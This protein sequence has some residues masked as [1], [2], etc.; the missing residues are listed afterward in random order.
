MKHLMLILLLPL[1]LNA[2][3]TGL[4]TGEDDLNTGNLGREDD[5]ESAAD[6]YIKL[7][8]EYMKRGNYAVALS[9]AKKAV[10]QD[11]RNANAHLVLA[12]IYEYLGESGSANAA[13]QRSLEVDG[14]NPYALNAYGS[15][16]CKLGE[17]ERA[18]PVFDRAL[19]NPLYQT[20]WVALANAGFCANKAGDLPR[21]QAYLL[22]A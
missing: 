2:C 10:Q 14:K 18:L 8:Q 20:P 19:Q 17:H 21:A 16:L 4:T 6:T 15:Y 7:A 1:F 9:K 5:Y 12:L 13:Y 3:A 11:P 22:K